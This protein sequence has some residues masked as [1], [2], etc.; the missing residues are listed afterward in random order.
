V[1][2]ATALSTA[3]A[4]RALGL[5]RLIGQV[6]TI[7]DESGDGAGF[8]AAG[9]TGRWLERP[10]AALAG[11]RPADLMSTADGQDVLRQMVARMQSSAYS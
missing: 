7:V 1:R 3:E 9:W 6:Q 8:D 5:A 11:Q 10:L 2:E 4:S